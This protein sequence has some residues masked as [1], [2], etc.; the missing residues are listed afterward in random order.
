MTDIVIN[1]GKSLT[2]SEY[3]VQMAEHF[4]AIDLIRDEMLA[5]QSVLDNLKLE[6]DALKH[7]LNRLFE[8]SKANLSR[9]GASL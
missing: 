9:L 3:R 6:T 8:V 2:K 5:Q 1:N 7:E 4:K